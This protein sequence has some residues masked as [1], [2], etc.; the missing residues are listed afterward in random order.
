MHLKET[1]STREGTSTPIFVFGWRHW[2]PRFLFDV[3]VF[4]EEHS[5]IVDW[6]SGLQRHLRIDYSPSWHR[7]SLPDDVSVSSTSE[8][9]LRQAFPLRLLPVR[10][11]SLI[12]AAWTLA[13]F[14]MCFSTCLKPRGTLTDV[15]VVDCMIRTYI[16]NYQICNGDLIHN[17]ADCL[18]WVV[19]AYTVTL[20]LDRSKHRRVFRGGG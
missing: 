10:V 8:M 6:H 19:Q 13:S 4:I 14:A 1:R 7:S 12:C 11:P 15:I 17:C 16:H 20:F 3:T 18:Q 5:D 2:Q 9:I